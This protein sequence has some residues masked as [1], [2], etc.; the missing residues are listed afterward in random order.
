MQ[1]KGRTKIIGTGLSGLIGSRVVELLQDAFQFIDLSLE[2]GVDIL[3]AD[4][5]RRVFDQNDDATVVLHLAAFTDTKS[6]WNQRGNKSGPC[7]RINVTGTRNIA[8][9]CEE[10]GMHLI[11]ISTDYVFSGAKKGKYT[12]SDKPDPIEWYGETKYVSEQIAQS[13]SSASIVRLS[14]PYR[15]V[16]RDKEDFV[17]RILNSILSGGAYPLFTDQTITPTFIDDI[18]FGMI[19]F[20]E[21]TPQGIYHLV[22][23]SSHSPYQIG[24]TIIDSFVLDNPL[25]KT[26]SLESYVK[27]LPRDSRP[28]QKNLSLSNERVIEM[29][30]RMSSL[31]EG[32]EKM[33]SQI[34]GGFRGHQ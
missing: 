24:Q 22:E 18:A 33:K 10:Y 23:S 4:L 1:K 21:N 30:I 8:D 29:G 5:L 9:L 34:M 25:I 28:W 14:F 16:F 32:L 20:F 19:Y 27:S 3:D 26:T 31:T 15:A 6:A 7:Y 17:R 13:I 11:H 2:S 12:E